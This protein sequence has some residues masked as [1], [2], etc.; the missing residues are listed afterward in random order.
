MNKEIM[1]AFRKR[2]TGAILAALALVMVLLLLPGVSHALTYNKQEALVGLKGVEV[3]VEARDYKG[4]SGG[5]S[6]DQIQT[7]VE[8]RLRKAGI[9]VLTKKERGETPGQ[10][11]LYVVVSTYFYAYLIEVGVREVVT[12]ARGFE[13]PGTIWQTG[14]LGGVGTERKR[15]IRESVGDQVDMFINDYLAANPK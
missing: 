4:E 8:L 7:D 5:L 13:A 9:R 3:I 12:L 6:R 14:L 10:P 1:G 15:M 2:F 11:D